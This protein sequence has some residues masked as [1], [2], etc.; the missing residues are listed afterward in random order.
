MSKD[1]NKRNPHYNPAL[2]DYV[3]DLWLKGT[4]EHVIDRLVRKKI[5]DVFSFKKSDKNVA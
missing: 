3:I 1:N 2:R 4:S 5:R